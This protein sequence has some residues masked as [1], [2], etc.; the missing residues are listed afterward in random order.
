[1]PNILQQ[2]Q[3]STPT[4]CKLHEGKRG[5]LR[6]A[7]GVGL[8]RLF[9]SNQ[10]QASRRKRREVRNLHLQ[11]I[12]EIGLLRLALRTI[13]FCG[14]CVVAQAQT[15]VLS[16]AAGGATVTGPTPLPVLTW[17]TGFG[18]VNGLGIGTPSAGIQKLPATGGEMYYTPFTITLAGANSGH[19]GEVRAY[20]SAP[21]STSS[22]VIQI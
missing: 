14:L 8:D 2:R 13:V 19:P 7:L 11:D 4:E 9:V 6:M 16:S 17:H 18:A 10:N 1:M 5:L 12:S 15:V 20:I 21:F 3:Q 22:N